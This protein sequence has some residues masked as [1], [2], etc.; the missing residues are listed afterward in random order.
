VLDTETLMFRK[1]EVKEWQIARADATKND[2]VFDLEY[3][4]KDGTRRRLLDQQGTITAIRDILILPP[5][6]P[7]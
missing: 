2:Y 4:M 1:A 7:A 3:F 6:P 5:P